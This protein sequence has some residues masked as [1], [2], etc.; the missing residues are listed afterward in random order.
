MQDVNTTIQI[1]K[2]KQKKIYLQGIIDGI[3]ALERH[4]REHYLDDNE[5]LDDSEHGIDTRLYISSDS[6]SSFYICQLEEVEQ[7]IEELLKKDK[8]ND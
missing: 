4:F 8:E 2:I 6:L 1:L 7:E 5:K 3:E